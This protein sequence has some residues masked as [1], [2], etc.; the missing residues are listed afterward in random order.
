MHLLMTVF[1]FFQDDER[2]KN[3][4]KTKYSLKFIFICCELSLRVVLLLLC[5]CRNF[6]FS[7]VVRML[8]KI[9]RNIW[10]YFVFFSPFILKRIQNAYL[11]VWM[12]C[13]VALVHLFA[14]LLNRLFL[15]FFTPKC[16]YS[17]SR[18]NFHSFDF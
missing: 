5:I 13:F 9:V 2:N 15:R 4:E 1:T 12:I 14:R 16:F 10:I 8:F 3:K 17:A 11:W 6:V 7:Y 18:I